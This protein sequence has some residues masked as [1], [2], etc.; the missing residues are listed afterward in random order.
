MHRA[1]MLLIL[2][3]SGH[4]VV[5]LKMEKVQDFRE[6]LTVGGAYIHAGSS[7]GLCGEQHGHEVR[8]WFCDAELLVRVQ[9]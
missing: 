2:E 8:S 6:W 4:E 7:A 1:E 3:F 9:V 5:E